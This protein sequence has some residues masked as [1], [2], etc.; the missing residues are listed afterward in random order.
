MVI[1]GPGV[2]ELHSA[3]RSDLSDDHVTTSGESLLERI[4]NRRMVV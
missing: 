1:K 2:V 4:K 3:S